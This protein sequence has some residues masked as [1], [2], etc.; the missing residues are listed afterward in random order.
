MTAQ[1]VS[2]R[3]VTVEDIPAICAIEKECHTVP[4]TTDG[5]TEEIMSEE[6]LGFVATDP[7]K[8]IVGYSLSQCILDECSINTI[9]VLPACQRVGIGKKLLA[10]TIAC[11]QQR[12][13]A[14]VHLEVRSKNVTAQAFYGAFGFV[15]WGLRKAYYASDGDDAILMSCRIMVK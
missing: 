8:G 14:V 1:T 2:I 11:S 9:A 10:E 15:K 7:D 3:A 13:V 4:W 6:C 5:F 12:D